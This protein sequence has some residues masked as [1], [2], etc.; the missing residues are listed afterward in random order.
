[1]TGHVPH[2][3]GHSDGSSGMNEHQN[4]SIAWHSISSAAPWHV[5]TVVASSTAVDVCVD[6][7]FG[8]GVGAEVGIGVTT[9][10]GAGVGVAV[11]TGVGADVGIGVGAAVGPGVGEDVGT[12]V[13]GVGVG[14]GVGGG[15]GR[16]VA[17]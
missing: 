2:N 3:A 8:D 14:D 16:A 7:V 5:G 1:M 9:M 15:G 10:V 6:V 12:G 4:E 13:S 11:G 17:G